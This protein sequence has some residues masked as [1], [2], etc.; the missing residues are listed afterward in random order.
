[1]KR[2]EVLLD[3]LRVRR[4]GPERKVLE[5]FNR[6][7]GMAAKRILVALLVLYVGWLAVAY[8]YHFIDGANLLFHEAGHIILGF[9]GQT[10]HFLG[11]TIGQLFFPVACALHFIQTGKFYEAWLMGIWFAESLMYTAHYLG[12]A[13]AQA[14]PL[15]GGHIHDWN[16]LLS[17]WGLLQ[18]CD[19]IARGLHWIAVAIAIA[20]LVAAWRAADGFESS[21]SF[22]SSESI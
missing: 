8:D 12:D 18:N 22:S 10:L 19:A 17:R 21:M 6:R 1:M 4:K 20:C 7:V 13:Q 15:V 11:G 3:E 2:S 14:L 16:W 5:A 9:M